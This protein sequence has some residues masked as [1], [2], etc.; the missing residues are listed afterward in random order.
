MEKEEIIEKQLK[1]LEEISEKAREKWPLVYPDTILALYREVNND[2]RTTTMIDGKEKRPTFKQL[3]YINDLGGDPDKPL[4]SKEASEYIEELK[5]HRQES[6]QY[7]QRI[8][9]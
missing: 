1:L 3:S 4:T 5:Q 8:D 2:L 9:E 6:K 7:K